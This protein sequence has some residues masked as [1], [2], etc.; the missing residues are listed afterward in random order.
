L[1]DARYSKTESLASAVAG[2]RSHAARILESYADFIKNSGIVGFGPAP[3]EYA[4][5]EGDERV[6]K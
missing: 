4:D 1:P 3:F 6:S 5:V 2:C